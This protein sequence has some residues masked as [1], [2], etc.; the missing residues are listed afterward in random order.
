[1]C[2]QTD[3]IRWDCRKMI[4]AKSELQQMWYVLERGLAQLVEV[5]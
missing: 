2:Q 5:L 4:V 1:M 3:V